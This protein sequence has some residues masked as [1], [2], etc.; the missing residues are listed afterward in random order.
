MVNLLYTHTNDGFVI[1]IDT[2]NYSQSVQLV[3]I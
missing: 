3:A 1:A 2:G